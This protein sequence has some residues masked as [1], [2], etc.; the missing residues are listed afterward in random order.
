VVFRPAKLTPAALKRGYDRAYRDFYS[1]SNIAR[2][3]GT[4]AGARHKLKHMAYAAGWKKFEPLWDLV[5]KARRLPLMTPILEGILSRV[6]GGSSK[7]P[8]N[9]QAPVPTPA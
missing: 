2:A 3:A 5:I 6:S 8:A 4:H 7:G 9:G 1:W